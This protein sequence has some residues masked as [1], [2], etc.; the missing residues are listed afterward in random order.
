MNPLFQVFDDFCPDLE[1][2]K[3]SALESGFGTWLPKK[4]VVG[5]SIYEG[6]NF[7]GMHSLMLKPLAMALGCPVFPNSMFFRVTKKDTE[8]AYVH[9]DRHDGAFTAICYMSEHVEVSG[10]GFYRHR[11]TGLVEMPEIEVVK[12]EYPLLPKDMTLGTEEDWEQLDFIRGLKN[13]CIVFHAPLFHA[14][15][16]RE[17][18]GE[19]DTSGRMVWVCHFNTLREGGGF[20]RG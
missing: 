18:F 10:T 9:S 20:A 3:V 8:G 11:G 4:G 15:T 12:Q 19:V 2:V 1:I 6:M 7:H 5:S 13:R 17:G 14:R 16:P